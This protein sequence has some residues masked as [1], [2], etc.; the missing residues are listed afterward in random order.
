[1]DKSV[2]SSLFEHWYK[3]WYW[4]IFGFCLIIFILVI[5]LTFN[6][7]YSWDESVYLVHTAIFSGKTYAFNEFGFRPVFISII[8]IPFYAISHNLIFLR[9]IMI[10][11]SIIFLFILFLLLKRLFDFKLALVL[12]AIF[13]VSPL[14]VTISQYILTDI[15]GLIFVVLGLYFSHKYYEDD[16]RTSLIFASVFIALAFLTRFFYGSFLIFLFILILFKYKSFKS[17]LLDL[18][19]MT[20]PFLVIISPYLIFSK[21]VY[22]GFLTTLKNGQIL[23]SHYDNPWYVYFIYLFNYWGL[24]FLGAILGVYYLFRRIK[25]KKY[26]FYI[27][28]LILFIF[29]LVYLAMTPHKEPRYSIPLAFD[30]VFIAGF[31]IYLWFKNHSDK[32]KKIAITIVFFLFLILVVIT[33]HFYANNYF[34][35][36]WQTPKHM[37]PINYLKDINAQGTIYVNTDVPQYIYLFPHNYVAN[38]CWYNLN[39]KNYE[40]LFVKSGY[41]VTNIW[42]KPL[43]LNFLGNK[44]KLIKDLPPYKVYQVKLNS[45]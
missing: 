26:G 4:Y 34:T 35:K 17:L 23:V 10:L 8:L 19:Y 27:S 32:I 1:M 44:I 24:F 22:G 15:L 18:V 37:L 45:S 12:T 16:K 43:D 13:G 28:F 5:T 3:Y 40:T 41:L 14:F 33:I 2:F 20:A 6:L 7:G 36:V 21:I 29:Q 30:L 25:N 31:G 38:V 11:F 42:A 39:D 9:I